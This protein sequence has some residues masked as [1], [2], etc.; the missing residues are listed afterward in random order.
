MGYGVSTSDQGRPLC[1]AMSKLTS[2]QIL[3]GTLMSVSDI[4]AEGTINAQAP[5]WAPASRP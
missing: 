5:R 4:Q 3:K 1:E 2:K